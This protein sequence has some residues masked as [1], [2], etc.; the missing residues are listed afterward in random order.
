LYGKRID[1]AWRSE[2]G[3]LAPSCGFVPSFYL[4]YRR[5]F[6]V[7]HKGSESKQQAPSPDHVTPGPPSCQTMSRDFHR[8]QPLHARDPMTTDGCETPFPPVRLRHTPAYRHVPPSHTPPPSE[9]REGEILTVALPLSEEDGQS[10]HCLSKS[11]DL[12]LAMKRKASIQ[13]DTIINGSAPPLYHVGPVL[14]HHPA[15]RE[16]GLDT[17][18]NL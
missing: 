1:S 11:L 18:R 13:I 16:S 4:P 6:P 2:I 14:D 5:F 12:L 8:Q 9:K 3:S 17:N 7:G 10:H 15:R